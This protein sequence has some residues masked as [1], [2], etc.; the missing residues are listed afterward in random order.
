MNRSGERIALGGLRLRALLAGLALEP[1]KLFTQE[2]LAGILWGEDQPVNTTNALQT[3]V[4]RLRAAMGLPG[5][6]MA[7]SG[8]Y[9]VD[10]DPAHVDAHRFARLAE[11]GH[12][13][14]APEAA[15]HAFDEA[16]ALW[17]GPALADLHAVPYLANAAA[18]LEE[19]RLAVIEARAEA[20]LALGRRIDLS[21]E[22]AEHPFRER[23]QG[24]AMRALAAS[25]RQAEALALYE[26]TRQA[27]AEGLGVDP[28]PDLRD[29]HLAVLR[30]D[31]VRP[32]SPAADKASPHENWIGGEAGARDDA[33]EDPR[34]YAANG[35]GTRSGA[36]DPRFAG[37]GGDASHDAGSQT[38]GRG[39]HRP[40]SRSADPRRRQA[41]ARAPLT[42]FVGREEEVSHV[43]DLLRVSRLV[44]IIG[45][46]GAGK[47]RL[48]VETALGITGSV[49]GGP[50][51]HAS[52]ALDT[53][54]MVELAPVT[55]LVDVPHAVLDALGVTADR[56]AAGE[57]RADPIDPVAQIVA[58]VGTRRLLLVLDNC[59]HVI[60][61]AALIA[62]RLVEECP[63][64]T[65]LATSREPLRVP[66]E[67]LV[68]IQPLRLPPEG[69]TVEEA[70][71]CPAVRLLLER[72]AGA[73]PGFALDESNVKSI[74]TICRR[75]DGM[76][77]AIELAAARLRALPPA[78]LAM[79]LDDRFRLL[80]AG[81]R[82]ALP[83][84]QTLRAVVEW[85]W[86]L[87]DPREQELA[88]RLAVFAGGATF[89]D[90]ERVCGD[91][92]P[93]SV[94][95]S[96]AYL[97]V[98]ELLP[99]L[100]DKSLVEMADDGRYRMLE[101]IRAFAL[102]RLGEA[103]ELDAFRRR[104]AMRFLA[105]VES[106]EPR[107]RTAD[108]I[109]WIDR[110][111]AE[112]DDIHAALRWALDRR[113]VELAVRLCG[114]LNWFWWLRG[115]RAEGAVWAE[116]VLM[117]AGEEP[118][119]GL[120]GAYA[121]CQ[122]AV[123]VTKLGSL[124]ADPD[125]LRTMAA[126]MDTLIDRAVREG[127]PHPMLLIGRVVMA[128]MGGQEEHGLALLDGYVRSD[129]PWLA[130]SARMIRGGF[131]PERDQSRQDLEAAVAGFRTIGER[132]GLSE[133]LLSLA[134]L[135]AA[136]GDL[137]PGLI[138]EVAE[139]TS[140]WVSAEE[141]VSTLTRLASLRAQAGD[142]EGAADDIAQARAAVTPDLPA[143]ALALLRIGEGEVARRRGDL[144]GALRVYEQV[145]ADLDRIPVIPQQEAWA[146]LAYARTLA[147][148]GD[149]A[150]AREHHLLAIDALGAAPDLP[151]LASAV[152]GFAITLLCAG[153]M[154]RA[155]VL[156]GAADA[157]HPSAGADTDVVAA[158]TA[159]R[160]G[161]GSGFDE[162]YARGAALSR[163]EVDR[164][165]RS[166]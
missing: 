101:T 15:A 139:L 37:A 48:T 35:P 117:L 107:L 7:R 145:I 112:Q 61:A 3:L 133:A 92:W 90:I 135:H 51:P 162:V 32:S 68:P 42:S 116:Q 84:H 115:Y 137:P 18:L 120:A 129:D 69:A 138:E 164:L 111:I 5:V 38:S 86:D 157:I 50:K 67:M 63:G 140:E 155:V 163:Q 71:D 128:F 56:P 33:R 85:S 13:E 136:R 6:I 119:S 161:L 74:V 160:S 47:T 105:L 122:F 166:T 156:F 23:L 17:R 154:E 10:V 113:D 158:T 25:G 73:R 20:Y 131:Q 82:T 150:A 12:A 66:G 21:A 4:K 153:D 121:G 77:L 98:L 132:W 143:H 41:T 134:S 99:S 53:L 123:D 31:P 19:R 27:L 16:L 57:W 130:S 49:A 141:V 165:L 11:R 83:R 125:R 39:A 36:G 58:A 2:R 65:V 60:D 55:D 70:R 147:E 109:E 52:A 127:S 54:R 72:A 106:A 79:R 30:G 43:G 104:H 46:G 118:P 96:A 45:P 26:N 100:V 91:E 24:L 80:T 44:T 110:L 149:F 81:N 29:A 152:A 159:A 64:V 97:D 87:L 103:G 94:T 146:H 126:R 1:G 14:R 9:L 88:R 76:P 59:E 22:A 34:K 148:R 8:G 95:G 75:L 89:D 93:P 124:L 62:R 142:L 114:S 40:A 28:G 78:Q 108:Q 144:D 151:V 102:E